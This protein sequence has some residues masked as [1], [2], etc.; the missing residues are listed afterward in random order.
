MTVR[1]YKKVINM[2]GMEQF[3]PF[4]ERFYPIEN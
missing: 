1:M 3:E 4:D 2:H